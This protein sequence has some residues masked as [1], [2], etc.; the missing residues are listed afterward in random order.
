MSSGTRD[1][2][3]RLERPRDAAPGRVDPLAHD[4][5]FE[6]VESGQA[7]LAHAGR[8]PQPGMERFRPPPERPLET[9]EVPEGAQPFAR[10]ARCGADSSLYSTSCERCGAR[11]DTPEQRRFNERLWA[12]RQAEAAARPAGDPGAPELPGPAPAEPG[13]ADRGGPDASLGVRLLGLLPSA[14]WR[15]AALAAAA[16]IP[17]LLLLF[18]RGPIRAAAMAAL[19]L[20]AVIFSPPRRWR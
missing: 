11:L 12:E 7:P 13:V 20:G 6:R 10:C 5:R 9:A 2:F 18:G 17:L 3:L 1:R 19:V 16:G 15:R 8:P 4:E 14:A